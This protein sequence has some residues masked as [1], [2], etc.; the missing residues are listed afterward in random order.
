MK[1][2]LI[3][4]PHF[5]PTNAADMH[6]ARLIAPFLTEFG[7]QPT[8]LCVAPKYIASPIDD[9]LCDDSRGKF[10]IVRCN[11]LSLSWTKVPGLGL[12]DARAY[13][14]MRSAGN[15]LIKKL[16]FDLI[17][18]TTTAFSLHVLGPYWK[19]KFGI[20]FSMDYQD[21]WVNE[22]YEQNPHVL[23]PGG[24]LKYSVA[25]A[26]HRYQERAVLKKCSGLTAVSPDYPKQLKE[27]YPWVANLPTAVIPFPGS[28]IDIER[29]SQSGCT[30]QIFNP[31]DGF[32]HWVYIGR[33]GEDMIQ[34]L[35]AFFS[36]LHDWKLKSP[37]EYSKT[38]I[39][40][41]GTSYAPA[42]RGTPTIKP[43]ADS[44]QVGD[45]VTESTDRV[46][47]SITL[48][49]LLDA[50]ALIVPGSNDPAYTASK[51]YPYL[52]A[53]K[54][55][56]AIFNRNSS[57]VEVINTCGGATLVTFDSN[58]PPETLRTSIVSSW[59]STSSYNKILELNQKLFYPYTDHG[60]TEL[61]A[62]FFEK[63]IENVDR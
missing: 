28:T 41:I 60:S 24:R 25:S 42:G 3:V 38:R 43:L 29:A 39:H 54:P 12:I 59:F 22:Y 44:C 20:P 40:F 11:A 53:R 45:V 27:R 5:P 61:V 21:P 56:L 10:E 35:R 34:S 51:L 8:V 33:G 16:G 2:V 46:K 7:W 31:D 50:D 23:P 30:Q 57:V 52:L 9:W 6:R 49:C 14:G 36:A 26:I 15:K 19:K 47:Y 58:T 55:M 17:Y 18:F 1:R 62:Q 63:T 32:R 37:E 13:W 4:S 48:R